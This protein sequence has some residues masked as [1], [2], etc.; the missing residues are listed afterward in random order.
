MLS[1]H[2]SRLG[3]VGCEHFTSASKELNKKT[4]QYPY[5][6][7]LCNVRIEIIFSYQ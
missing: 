5:N 2:T 7:I 3:D 6:L 1:V 4:L